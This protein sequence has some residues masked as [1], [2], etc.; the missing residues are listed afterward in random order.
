MA[1]SSTCKTQDHETYGE[2]LRAKG[3]QI[4]DLMNSGIQ[5]AGAKNLENYRNARKHGIQPRSTNKKDVDRA[6][7]ISDKTGQAYQA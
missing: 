7:Q 3:I 2:C 6:V 4:G 5:K 1:C